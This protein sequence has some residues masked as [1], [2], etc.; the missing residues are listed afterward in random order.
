MPKVVMLLRLVFLESE[1]RRNILE[2]ARPRPCLRVSELFADDASIRLERAKSI[3]R[4]GLCVVR[5]GS[6]A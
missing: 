1:R 3:I 5:V 6:S 2:S 4:D